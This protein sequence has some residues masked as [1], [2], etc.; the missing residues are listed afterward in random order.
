MLVAAMELLTGMTGRKNVDM[1]WVLLCVATLTLVCSSHINGSHVSQLKRRSL[2]MFKRYLQLWS[3]KLCPLIGKQFV[4]LKV[5]EN[6]M[7]VMRAV[8]ILI[9]WKVYFVCILCHNHW[10]FIMAIK[11][12]PIWS[13]KLFILKHRVSSC[14]KEFFYSN[15]YLK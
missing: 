8:I 11:K 1:N 10:Q 15:L 5:K 14:K 4:N 3:S 7:I 2:S 12:C 13:T 6:H 9:F